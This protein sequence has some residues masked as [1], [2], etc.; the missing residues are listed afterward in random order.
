MSESMTIQGRKLFAEDIKLIR[1]LFDDNPAWHCTW[2]SI[3]LCRMWNW[4]TD[5]GQLKD[6]AFRTMLR[7]LKQ[8]Q[9][10]VLPPPLRPGNHTRHMRDIP[11]S[12]DHHRRIAG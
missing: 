1:R 9:L 2:L 11:H 8:R 6:I 5:K 4:R 7:K 10:V 3:E 12:Y